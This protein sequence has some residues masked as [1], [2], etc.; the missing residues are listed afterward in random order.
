MKTLKNQLWYT[1]NMGY[2]ISD[3]APLGTRKINNVSQIRDNSNSERQT[4]LLTGKENSFILYVSAGNVTVSS[5]LEDGLREPLVELVDFLHDNVAPYA[6]LDSFPNMALAK[7]YFST[8]SSGLNNACRLYQNP[9]SPEEYNKKLKKFRSTGFTYR[10]LGPADIPALVNLKQEW[11]K[12][13]TEIA[14]KKINANDVTDFIS[15]DKHFDEISQIRQ[16][17]QGVQVLP[18]EFDIAST[19]GRPLTTL[20][21]AFDD[22]SLVAYCETEGN[23]S[24]QAFHSRANI[25]RNSKSPQEFLDLNLAR[26]FSDKGV[27]IF[28]RGFVNGPRKGIVGLIEYKRKFGPL[29]PVIESSYTSV[30]TAK[31]Q[32]RLYLDELFGFDLGKLS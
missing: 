3:V 32:E 10:E 13:K 8:G 20:Y 5:P 17:D 4:H 14:L 22:D 12:Q 24:L 30:T 29:T 2:E 26:D 1:C 9:L 16:E 31:T 19:M 11:A 28:D 27:K 6:H 25:R 15:L 7:H 21:G 18:S 23:N